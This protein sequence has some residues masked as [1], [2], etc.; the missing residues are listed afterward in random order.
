[1]LG[2]SKKVF[3]AVFGALIVGSIIGYILGDKIPLYSNSD[4]CTSVVQMEIVL[5]A[6]LNDFNQ[7]DA[8]YMAQNYCAVVKGF[9]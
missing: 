8:Y 7:T 2:F 6:R 3:V 9:R 4:E 1:M 5:N